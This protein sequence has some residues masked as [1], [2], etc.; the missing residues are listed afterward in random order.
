MRFLNVRIATGF[1]FGGAIAKYQGR[2]Y[3]PVAKDTFNYLANETTSG[4]KEIAK[5]IQEGTHSTHSLSC[6]KCNEKNP[7]HAKF[8]NHCGEKL[9]QICPH[10]EQENKTDALYCNRCGKSLG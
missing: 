10:C 4:V 6:F 1:G 3:A 5:A 8:C 9:V 7:I 2:E